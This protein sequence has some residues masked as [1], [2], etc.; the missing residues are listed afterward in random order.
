M[1]KTIHRIHLYATLATLP[2]LSGSLLTATPPATAQEA[3]TT[4]RIAGVALPRGGEPVRD[5]KLAGGMSKMLNDAAKEVELTPGDGKAEVLFWTGAAYK[6]GR[7]PFTRTLLQNALTEA[8]Y[9]YKEFTENDIYR[10]NRFDDE[11]YGLASALQFSSIDPRD[12]FFQATHPGK[13]QTLM[14][15]W[16]NQEEQKRLVL[17]LVPVGF[18]A[19]PVATKVP[20]VTDPN[21]F[22]VQDLLNATRGMPAR[23]NPAF[24]RMT[25]KPG[26]VRGMVKDG[27]GKP[28]AGA[29]IVVQSSAAGGFRTDSRGRTNAQGIYEFPVPSGVCQVVNA[30]CRVLYNGKSLL[31][32]LHPADSERDHFPS[33]QGHVENFVLR[34]SGAAREGQA[35][36]DGS[37]SYGGRIR[38]LSY[39]I[40]RGGV[41]EVTLK[42]LG[43][44]ADGTSGRTLLFRF[45]EQDARNETFLGGIPLGRYSLTARVYDGEDALALRIKK[46]FGTETP[47]VPSMT[48][49]FEDEGGD[50]AS[51]GSSG[52]KRLELSLQ[53]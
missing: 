27:S 46:T 44:L 45:P 28:I 47:L 38:L 10:T 35:A 26:V 20:E 3:G 1:Q 30:D 34:T 2:L 11:A 42:P 5:Q 15:V 32:P 36:S 48:V 19:G 12:V 52:I 14:G 53:P 8:G 39:A 31:L 37:S 51:L 16:I 29:Q 6:P 4:S 41:L 23:P 40:P 18:S 33:K 25:P 24:P 9:T 21:T 7:A 13:R 17:G 50:L 22:L 49:E 43:T